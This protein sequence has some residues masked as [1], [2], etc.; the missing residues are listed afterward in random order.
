MQGGRCQQ[1]Q[2]DAG[3]GSS[4][5]PW[6]GDAAMAPGDTLSQRVCW[7]LLSRALP[8]PQHSGHGA[9]DGLSRTGKVLGWKPA[10]CHSPGWSWGT[11]AGLRQGAPARHG[12]GR[13]QECSGTRPGT[14]TTKR[15][16]YVI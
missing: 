2:G 8:A 4:L 14:Q 16:P 12:A 13:V 15:S 7:G 10:S 3:L 6:D 1:G 9:G 5:C 11:R